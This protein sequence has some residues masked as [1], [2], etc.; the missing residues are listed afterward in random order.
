[1]SIINNKL[2]RIFD[3]TLSIS[4]VRTDGNNFSEFSIYVSKVIENINKE[5]KSAD[6]FHELN[7][8]F[9]IILSIWDDHFMSTSV[10]TEYSNKFS[11]NYE[12]K[13]KEYSTFE[14]IIREIIR[15]LMNN[16]NEFVSYMSRRSLNEYGS[17]SN[18]W[19]LYGKH[20]KLICDVLKIGL[21]LPLEEMFDITQSRSDLPI[22]LN[23]LH[24]V[25]RFIK[26]Y[27]WTV[28]NILNDG[29]HLYDF[30]KIVNMDIDYCCAICYDNTTTNNNKEFVKI[31]NGC[32]HIYCFD[33]LLQSLEKSKNCPYCRSVYPIINISSI[34]QSAVLEFF[35]ERKKRNND[36][37]FMKLDESKILKQFFEKNGFDITTIYT[38][39]PIRCFSTC[40]NLYTK[41]WKGSH[42]C[43]PNGENHHATKHV[44]MASL[45][46]LHPT[47]CCLKCN[48]PFYVYREC[49]HILCE[50]H[51]DSTKYCCSK[52]KTRTNIFKLNI[53][54]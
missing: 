19:D 45:S 25:D 31:K 10:P 52:C 21:E 3:Y 37:I 8:I 4:N 23:V 54:T 12:N 33:C 5:F 32:N 46:V 24:N 35:N 18:K 9:D 22:H 39:H 43:G 51:L 17:F 29:Q 14:S 47:E 53:T 49:G 42:K 2:K 15:N 44:G 26:I 13:P 50:S 11:Y 38:E 41:N 40:G 48:G 27:L 36:A 16:I 7:L 1:M 34:C 30:E 28:L 20:K 6:N